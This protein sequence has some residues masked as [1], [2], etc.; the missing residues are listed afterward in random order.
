M[1]VLGLIWSFLGVVKFSDF[2]IDICWG[3][4]CILFR[5][6]FWDLVGSLFNN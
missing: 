4:G 2:I 6:L 3:D 1:I 5:V